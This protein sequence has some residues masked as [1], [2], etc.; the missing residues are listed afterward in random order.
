MEVTFG[1]TV[2]RPSWPDMSACPGTG[3]E[4]PME[5][6]SESDR[7]ACSGCEAAVAWGGL[8]AVL[9]HGQRGKWLA[10]THQN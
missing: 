6:E 1:P 2:W 10:L 7:W 5:F 3:A 9:A 8:A 4:H